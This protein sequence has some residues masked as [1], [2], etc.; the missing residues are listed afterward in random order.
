[1]LEVGVNHIEHAVRKQE[2][3]EQHDGLEDRIGRFHPREEWHPLMELQHVDRPPQRHGEPHHNP[4]Q[5]ER[6]HFWE[7]TAGEEPAGEGRHG[8]GSSQQD[9]GDRQVDRHIQRVVWIVPLRQ[10][11]GHVGEVQIAAAVRLEE[12][13]FAYVT[14]NTPVR[15]HEAPDVETP[16]LGILCGAL[17]NTGVPHAALADSV[18][19]WETNAWISRGE[20]PRILG[21]PGQAEAAAH[22]LD[23]PL[24][25]AGV[26]AHA[27]GLAADLPHL[28]LLP[29]EK[30]GQSGVVRCRRHGQPQQ[31]SQQT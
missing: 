10:T 22:N 6:E 17:T 11:A 21:L 29:R 15:V 8:R 1:M 12:C 16:G 23:Q 9:G 25:C 4:R 18:I 27:A 3:E 20:A 31:R 2:E 14:R 30:L 13:R 19:R 5:P 24:E 28:E 26:R 7:P